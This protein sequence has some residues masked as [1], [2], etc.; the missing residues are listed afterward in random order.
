[1][2]TMQE[3]YIIVDYERK[4]FSVHQT[5]FPATREQKLTT[6]LVKDVDQSPRTYKGIHLSRASLV[7]IVVGSILCLV[8]LIIGSVLCYRRKQG[9][10]KV[11]QASCTCKSSSN[12]A[13]GRS[14]LAGKVAVNQL[15]NTKS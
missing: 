8:V 14:E 1:M 12:N 3:A 13:G 7:G 11:N 15:M 6:I 2:E 4:N 10:C 5:S 9:S